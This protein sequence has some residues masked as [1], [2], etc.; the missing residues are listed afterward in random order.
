M[1]DRRRRQ[2]IA[3]FPAG[4]RSVRVYA[5][6]PSCAYYSVTFYLP[7][8]DRQQRST[9]GHDREKALRWAEAKAA[10]LKILRSIPH[11]ERS[12]APFRQCVTAFLDRDSNGRSWKRRTHEKYTETARLLPEVFLDRACRTITEESL[13]ELIDD[14]APGRKR[15]T[16]VT[17]RSFLTNLV[18]FG[19]RRYWL[20]PGQLQDLHLSIPISE[21]QE[22]DEDEVDAA[23]LPTRETIDELLAV[24]PAQHE[25]MVKL[26]L[27]TGLRFGEVVALTDLDVTPATGKIR[28]VR[29]LAESNRGQKWISST[30]NRRRRTVVFPK[31]LYAEIRDRCEAAAVD[32]EKGGLGLLFPAARGGY[33]S[34]NNFGKRVWR[35]AVASV[36][37]L[38]G[39]FRFHDLRHWAAV[40][41]LFDLEL[42][43]A[44]VSQILGHRDQGVTERIYLRAR[45]DYADRVAAAMGW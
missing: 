31:D 24:I 7:G 38:N 1:A 35:P 25:L 39:K 32:R 13:Q 12:D 33:I 9:V 14:Y 40:S 10:E 29:S 45:H 44:I 2:P 41:M 4:Y 16:I 23:S 37:A 19:R 5:P 15:A 27:A 43:V 28:I 21:E 34:R 8:K 6:T 3:V 22:E 11:S 18:D 36:P 30:K 17:Y 42:Q 26:V 20:L